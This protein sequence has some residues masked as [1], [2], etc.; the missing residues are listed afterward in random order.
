MLVRVQVIE[1][2]FQV[3][4]EPDAPLYNAQERG[5]LGDTERKHIV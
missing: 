3:T 2:S 5:Q 1:D 4:H